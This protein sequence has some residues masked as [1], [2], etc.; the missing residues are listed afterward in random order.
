MYTVWLGDEKV[1]ET[2][3]ELNSHRPE[4]AGAFVPT[5]YGLTVMPRITAK[6]NALAAFHEL[7]VGRGL[8]PRR[9]GRDGVHAVADAFGTTPEGQRLV[10][11]FRATAELTVRDEAGRECIWESL[12]IIDL[13]DIKAAAEA[14]RPD[15]AATLP[16]HRAA[17]VQ[18]MI[19]VTFAA[20]NTRNRLVEALRA[21]AAKLC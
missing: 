7:C 21:Q 12:S 11:A 19:A 1:G 2:R 14:R 6:F 17:S 8:D 10:E 15:L 16:D 9:F 4:R 20:P 18:Y 13:D 5:E 3:L